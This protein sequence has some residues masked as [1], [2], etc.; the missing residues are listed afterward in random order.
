[1]FVSADFLAI[2]YGIHD[3]VA[4]FFADREPPA[5]NLYWHG[6]LLYLRHEAGYLFIPIIVDTLNKM[7]IDRE[8]LLGNQYI[9]LLE[10]IGH[11][12]ALQE[13]GQLTYEQAIN[14]CILLTSGKEVNANFYKALVNYMQGNSN[15]FIKPMCAPFAALHRG[16]MF[17]FSLA[18]LNF[19]DELAVKIIEFWFAL[20]SSF[21][22]L[23]D[24]DDFEK[25]KK[26]TDENTFLQSALDKD[27]A[28]KLK[29]LITHNLAVLV[30]IN[31]P[32]ARVMETQFIKM[33]QLPHIHQYLNQ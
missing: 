33:N 20:I 23:D 13:T 4:K 19:S 7:G 9:D 16:D 12:A 17:L 32:L 8:I 5:N 29:T 3:K 18:V 6:K 2:Q 25:D 30:N 24:A 14:E 22:M 28:S 11:I 31:K 15:N 21:L 27:G 1:M 10:Q 26:N